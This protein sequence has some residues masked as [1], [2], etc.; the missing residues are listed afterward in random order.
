MK[1]DYVLRVRLNEQEKKAIDKGAKSASLSV[2]DYVRDLIRR[3][4]VHRG[5]KS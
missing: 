3:Y 5:D 2:A 4:A 1:R